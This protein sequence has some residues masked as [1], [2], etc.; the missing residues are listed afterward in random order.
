M[1]TKPIVTLT[2]RAWVNSQQA[3]DLRST[4]I[5]M[6]W[7]KHVSPFSTLIAAMGN[8]WHPGCKE[9]IEAMCQFT[10]EAGYE[11]TFYEEEDACY[12]PYDS[13]GIMRN[14]AYYRALQ[15]GYEYLLY[16]DNDIQPQPDTLVKLLHRYVPILSPIVRY[17]DGEA[18]GLTLPAMESGK[19]LAMVSSI[20]LSCLLFQT[21]V[22]LPYALTRFWQDSLGAGETYHFDKL[23]MTGHRPF[24]DT[25]VVVTCVSPPHFPLDS[26]SR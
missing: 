19:G 25:D 24:V 16:V 1:T 26:R 5:D 7:P 13:L 18:H 23:A 9:A 17:A 8:Y 22:F 14:S 2:D 10:W 11:V 4:R 3:H 15:E 20:V 12:A 21:S 6:G